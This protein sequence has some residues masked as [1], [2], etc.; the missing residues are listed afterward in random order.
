MEHKWTPHR[1]RP[2]QE[3]HDTAMAWPGGSGDLLAKKRGTDVRRSFQWSSSC[4]EDGVTTSL[5]FVPAVP[6]G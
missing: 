5:D 6:L 3:P 2:R 4:H 1:A